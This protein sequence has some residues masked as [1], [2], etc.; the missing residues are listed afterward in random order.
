MGLEHFY[1]FVDRKVVD[2]LLKMTWS[3]FLQYHPWRR[4]AVEELLTFVIEPEPDRATVERVLAEH[5]LRWTMKR[6]V[7]A[8]YFL[9]EIVHHV[10]DL[11]RRCPEVWL[12][13]NDVYQVAV[14]D[15]VAAEAY[16]AGRMNAAD[17]WA[18][19]NIDGQNDP[20]EWCHFSRAERVRIEH[21]LLP[22]AVEKPIFC[23]QDEA[24]LEDGY[25]CLRVR[26]TGRF[27]RFVRLAWREN[28]SVL[29]LRKDARQE[30]EIPSGATPP[31]RDFELPRQLMACLEAQPLEGHCLVR[32]FG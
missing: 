9:N 25:R 3:E 7:P 5:S 19:F 21:A 2:A 22:G 30:L 28:W 16:L 13:K 4:N 8:Y 1:W 18:V 23:W 14:L 17:Y 20:S 12:G 29:R 11:E 15:A 27:I 32:Y 26:D 6:A 10:P 24:C 31:F